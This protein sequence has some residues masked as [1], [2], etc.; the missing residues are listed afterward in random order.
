MGIS[1]V[2]SHRWRERRERNIGR[3]K[4]RDI[5]SDKERD[6]GSDRERDREMMV[7]RITCCKYLDDICSDIWVFVPCASNPP[8]HKLRFGGTYKDWKSSQPN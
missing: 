4:E 7:G 5:G 6:R 2:I 1:Y 8:P 3:D